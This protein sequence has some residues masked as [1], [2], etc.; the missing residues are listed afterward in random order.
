MSDNTFK[1]IFLI[2]LIVEGIIRFPFVNEYRKLE[3]HVDRFT[4]VEKVLLFIAFLGTL[5]IPVLY[6]IEPV[7]GFADYN[8]PFWVGWTGIVVLSFSV[9]IFWRSHVDLGKS[10]SPTLQIMEDHQLKTHGVYRYIRHPMY[11][12]MWLLAIAQ[13]LLLQNWIAGLS[14]LAGFFPLYVLRVPREERMMLEHFGEEYNK[15]MKSTG[16]IIPRY[17][18][19]KGT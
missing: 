4:S 14:G 15:Y 16:R 2:G 7:F 9:W 1:Y 12:S 17:G 3:L 6:I 11:A 5:F 13:G 10:W 18:T 19:G 8:R